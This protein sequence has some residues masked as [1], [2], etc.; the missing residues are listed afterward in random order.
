MSVLIRRP[1]LQGRAT[2]DRMRLMRTAALVLCAALS[3]AALAPATPAQ[4]QPVAQPQALADRVDTA[5]YDPVAR[6]LWQKLEQNGGAAATDTGVRSFYEGRGF[7]PA[8]SGS[9][10][11]L[12]AAAEVRIVLQQAD[13]EGLEPGRY[14]APAPSADSPEATAQGDIALTE[15]VLRYAHDVHVGRLVPNQ[16]YDPILLP[17]RS[18]DAAGG[19]EAAVAADRVG[20]WLRSLPP[21]SADYAALRA[22]LAR[23]RAIEAAGG[24][25][26]VPPVAGNRIEEADPAVLRTLQDR[27]AVEDPTIDPGAPLLTPALLT[28]AVQRYQENHGLEPDGRPGPA[29][30]GALNRPVGE[31]VQQ[32]VANM[33]RWRWLPRDFG[34]TAIVVDLAGKRLK[35]LRNGESVLTSK[36]IAGARPTPTP[37][38]YANVTSVTANPPWDVPYSIASKE[39]LPKLRRNPHYLAQNNMVLRNGPAGDPYGES[40]DWHAVG[41]FPYR[42]RQLPGPHTALGLVKLEMPNRY[43]IFLHDTPARQLFDRFDR[44]LSHGCVRV[45]EIQQLASNLLSGGESSQDPRLQAAL[46][47]GQ[48]TG[49]SPPE[50]VPAYLLYWTAVAAPDGS[51]AF[52]P[53]VY[54]YDQELA[55]ALARLEQPSA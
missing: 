35:L 2:F 26:E 21:V 44:F 39:I 20:P 37:I 5:P 54:G 16:V 7:Q 23:Y 10:E 52:R 14:G 46:S 30:L 18:F 38:L 50:P 22:G 45:E 47:S 36:V 43:A 33:E 17:A 24:W 3:G 8:W 15:A 28:L 6:A 29:T 1:T 42:I 31:R 49:L 4:A 41:S 32:I 53:D 51:L 48:T 9:P 11:A 12:R 34:P 13:L 40:V 55:A 27:L 19:L 25:A